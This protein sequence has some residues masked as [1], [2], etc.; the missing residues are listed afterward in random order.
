MKKA[1]TLL[2]VLISITIFLI[3]I[4]FLYKTIDQT[5][6]SNNL[7]SKKEERL[8][9]LN[10]LHNIFL[11]D[12]AE[13][14]S[15]TILFDKNKNSIVKIVTNNTYHNSYFNNVTYLINSTEKFIRIES[16]EAFNENESINVAFFDNSY[17]D[18]LIADIEYFEAKNSGSNYNFFIKQK[19]KERNFFN[20]YKLRDKL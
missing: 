5:K 15:V 1:F 6:H 16:L 3:L 9:E 8:K 10:H 19:T 18:V 7:F 13:A 2:E 12:I 20:I 11:E 4:V 14:S 17:I